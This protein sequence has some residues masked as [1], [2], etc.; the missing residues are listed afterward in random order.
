[1]N[2]N[3]LVP[4]ILGTFSGFLA[5]LPIG[6]AKIL[7]VRKF[8]ILT[9][10]TETGI[11][12]L[13]SANATLI[14]NIG[15]LL[16][17]QILFFL[18]LQ[19]PF[20]YSLWV[21]PH[22]FS[23]FFL[24]I[25][26]IY[27]ETIKTINF[28]VYNNQ[29]L[30][31]SDSSF[32]R[33]LASF[34][35]TLFIQLLNPIILPNPVFCR[36]NNL[37]LFRYSTISTF[38]IGNIL[39]LISGYATFF[40]ST[41]F[42]LKKLELDAP[43]IYRLFKIKIHQFFLI[44]FFGFSFLCLSRSPIL[45]KDYFIKLTP[46]FSYNKSLV[47]KFWP[48]FFFSSD[49]NNRPLRLLDYDTT[50]F[51]K[52]ESIKPFN[53]MFFSQF[54]FE[55]SQ[56]DGKNY[57]Y[58]NFPQNLSIVSHNITSLVKLPKY[59][60]VE[61][62][63]SKENTSL[64]TKWINEKKQRLN[65][66]NK[67]FANKINSLEKG[68]FLE[69][70]IDKK[71][72]SL[73]KQGIQ[74]SKQLDP[75]LNA[76]DR[77]AKQVFFNK[78][79]FLFLTEEYCLKKDSLFPI[80]K[81]KLTD[82][83]TKNKLKL[84]L[85][86]KYQDINTFP[87]I[88]WKSTSSD[89]SQNFQENNLNNVSFKEKQSDQNL[90]KNAIL[91]NKTLKK[92]FNYLQNCL[93]FQNQTIQNEKTEW[94]QDKNSVQM[95]PIS[96]PMPLYNPNFTRKAINYLKKE[97]SGFMRLH[98]KFFRFTIF[99]ELQLGR[100]CKALAWNIFQKKAHAPF[101]L[102]Q[103]SLLKNFFAKKNKPIQYER[104]IA[105]WQPIGKPYPFIRGIFLSFQAYIRKYLTLPFLIVLKNSI[106]QLLFQSA[107][108]EK[109]WTNLSKEQYIDCDYYGKA[110]YIGVKFPNFYSNEIGKQI[111]IVKPFELRFWTRSYTPKEYLDD[112]E[113][114]S[115]L[116]LWGRE[117]KTV[118]GKVK[119][120]PS[121]KKLLIERIKLILRYK[122]LKHLSIINKPSKGNVAQ[123]VK[124]EK[125]LVSPREVHKHFNTEQT[126]FNL[127][128]IEEDKI[129]K[130]NKKIVSLQQEYERKR[131]QTKKT[132]K[133]NSVNLNSSF[134]SLK[135]I[136]NINFTRK[137]SFESIFIILQKRWFYFYRFLLKKER[138][139]LSSLKIKLI[140][141]KKFYFQQ[142]KKIF[143][144][145]SKASLN[146]FKLLSFFYSQLNEIFNF[147]FKK[148]INIQKNSSYNLKILKKSNKNLSQAYIIHSIW[149]DRMMSKPDITFL[150][151]L[152][153]HT[154][155]LNK[156]LEIFLNEQ[157]ILGTEKPENLTDYHWKE[158]LRTFQGY[159]PSLKLWKSIYPK[160]W[161]Q[162]VEQYWQKLP[163]SQL[164]VILNN[165][166]QNKDN[167]HNQYKKEIKN[168]FFEY[169]LP[170]F[171]TV[172]KQK[173]LWIFNTLSHIYTDL[174]HD[175]DVDSYFIWKT[176]NFDKK[177][178]NFFE[179]IKKIEDKNKNIS[180]NPNSLSSL[181]DMK[182]RSKINNVQQEI[183][184]DL[185]IIQIEKKRLDIDRKLERVQERVNFFPI[186]IKRW[187]I[188]KLKNKLR[189]LAKAVIKNPKVQKYSFSLNDKNKKVLQEIF[190]SENN[191]FSDILE[192]WNSKV[193]DDELVMYNII[194]SILNFTKKKHSLLNF[195]ETS[196][197][198]PNFKSN[199]LE[200]YFILP[201]EIFLPNH[202]H[203]L[204][205]LE[206][207]DF[208]NEKENIQNVF[209]VSQSKII[210]ETNKS[211]IKE[212]NIQIEFN[213]K[214]CLI[215]E[216]NQNLFQSRQIISR[217]LWP[218]HRLEDLACINRFWLGATQQSRFSF[219]RIQNIPLD[220]F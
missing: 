141:I 31:S 218:T 190:E 203:E 5:T 94:I 42:L 58:H 80:E 157:G 44:V 135:K 29:P 165:Q 52:N 200:N 8:L 199:F 184:K 63:E 33:I 137:Y 162:K 145:F 98:H 161:T 27:L 119:E 62:I 215:L 59:K 19:Y 65:Q 201:E 24:V 130:L 150:M 4:F 22:F 12:N 144:I 149:A 108:W 148:V 128:K 54:F 166:T 92:I 212:K 53:K 77:G 158:W 17:A 104:I 21:K 133:E 112:S 103:L 9:K 164:Q 124:V 189:N 182:Q 169:H 37:F 57:L 110:L 48:D 30:L 73:N 163:S 118:F 83:F 55:E 176:K 99:P 79:S 34:F 152:W 181:I 15:G 85:T 114:Y 89:I 139:F 121:F 105:Q 131:F 66:I 82:T 95:I 117:T 76:N 214:L 47:K 219:L 16:F 3:Y 172:Q 100:K 136:K 75:R 127:F 134:I 140:Q 6:P 132:N 36:L 88:S 49:I 197:V 69:E 102:N 125:R 177:M 143:K 213:K 2:T 171:Q 1:M 43:T 39:G 204:K 111:K 84:F 126:D 106:R 160:Y 23:L 188:K 192:N 18:A 210:D 146:I 70:L 205:I 20:L 175:G 123:D 35:E 173:K 50:K 202:L 46:K 195:E 60:Q 211:Q 26:F 7:T 191:I 41:T 217:F 81:K 11:Y 74:I 86:Q 194:S 147:F 10:G 187:K 122:I 208:E 198:V 115:F 109:D 87:F 155:L 185:P 64:L 138:K 196:F 51:P 183:L 32:S 25:I 206:S 71:L 28:D 167:I 153:N 168:K 129:Q 72:S 13:K 67:I 179:K 97:H 40:V 93:N 68:I 178:I 101:F 56:K 14:A 151:R 180:L 170:L 120:A 209:T 174:S 154:N 96:K 156:K 216:Q 61:S 116:T 193:L 107:E 45:S 91:K 38:L 142:N 78:K 159:T 186:F 90:L 113:N 207:L 220:Y